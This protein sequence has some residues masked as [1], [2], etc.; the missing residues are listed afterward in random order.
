MTSLGD[1]LTAVVRL[2]VRPPRVVVGLRTTCGELV[3]R[4]AAAADAEPA[5]VVDDD[6]RVVGALG[7]VDVV[8]HIAFKAAPD[9]P[10]AHATT[11]A[12][13]TLHAGERLYA[14]VVKMRRWRCA[15]AVVVDDDRRLVG[16]LALD[17]ALRTM[18]TGVMRHLDQLAF[19]PTLAAMRTAKD[20]QAFVARA[21][22]DEAVPA[23]DVL[24]LIAHVNDEIYRQVI[25]N[26]LAA[27]AENGWGP[28]PRPFA[29]IVMGSSGRGESMLRPDQDN[30]FVIADYPDD[31]HNAIDRY[32][33]ELASRMTRDLDAVGFP[34]CNGLVMATNPMWRKT[35]PQWRRQLDDWGRHRHAVALLYADIFFDLRTVHGDGAL[36]RALR[37]H[38]LAMVAARRAFLRDMSQNESHHMVGL[39]WFQRFV[40]DSEEGP[41][42]GEVNLKRNGTLPVVEA[43]RLLALRENIAATATLDRIAALAEKGVLS[44]DER[45]DIEAAYGTV[46]AL[47]L[48]QQVADVLAGGTPSSYVSPAALTRRESGELAA[49]MKAIE[50]LGLRVRADFTGGM[51]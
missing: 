5:V 32:F 45:G 16:L 15:M 27:M 2:A 40:T 31:D 14:A 6:G 30:G 26:A 29:T 24:R 1:M 28:A 49:A 4:M 42:Q 35:L 50:R 33:L 34:F 44:T 3:D 8:R 41:H 25:D 47:L 13:D 20:R 10:L 9:T 17:D 38:A 23:H 48:R 51:L 37:E 19:T 36:G 21:L 43:I 11:V 12:A 22:L 7:A 18:A 46:T 39:G